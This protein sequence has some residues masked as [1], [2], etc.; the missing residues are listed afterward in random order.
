M[1]KTQSFEIL[2]VGT[3]NIYPIKKK[4]KTFQLVNSE[5]EAVEKTE[6]ESGSSAVYVWTDSKGNEYTKEQVFYD[7]G[8]R[9]IQKIKKTEKVKT[10]ELT[11][12]TEIYDLAETSTY[13]LEG[14]ETTTKNFENKVG[15]KAIRFVFKKSSTGLKFHNAFIFRSHNEILMITG[16][17]KIS[18]GITEFKKMK[19]SVKS[20]NVVM[21][22]VVEI[23]ADEIEGEILALM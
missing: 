7:I 10:F 5:G 8:G 14:N 4:E 9:K 16:V 13:L 21:K 18:E 15:D 1:R 19:Q 22:D 20:K 6:K 11:D 2:G 23:Q 12:R 3:F 17:G